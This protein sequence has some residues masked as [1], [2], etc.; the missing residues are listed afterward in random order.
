MEKKIIINTI[1]SEDGKTSLII[2]SSYGKKTITNL[3]TD[4]DKKFFEDLEEL[5]KNYLS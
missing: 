4:K 5:V 2:N 3:S 1:T